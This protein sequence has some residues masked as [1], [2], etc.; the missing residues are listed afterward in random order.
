MRK[1][2]KIILVPLAIIGIYE[3]LYHLGKFMSTIVDVGVTAKDP[4][5]AAYPM[6]GLAFILGAFLASFIVL[7]IVAGVWRL[8][9][10]LF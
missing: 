6:I 8:I 1:A 4:L 9:D 7:R 5:W 2:V 10:D 3:G